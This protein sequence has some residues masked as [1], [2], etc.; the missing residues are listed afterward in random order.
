VD[1]LPGR[2]SLRTDL[3][4][5]PPQFS[6]KIGP[7]EVGGS[8]QL[9]E[10]SPAVLRTISEMHQPDVP[11]SMLGTNLRLAPGAPRETMPPV[12][13]EP[14]M[15]ML[16]HTATASALAAANPRA[17]LSARSE[18]THGHEAAPTLTCRW[19]GC[20]TGFVLR[21]SLRV[22]SDAAHCRVRG[23]QARCFTERPQV[24]KQETEACPTPA[25]TTASRL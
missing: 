22:G 10:V 8:P 14:S 11:P 2:L 21:L 9:K 13:I 6:A 3:L 19:I 17:C 7:V 20:D 24:R 25:Q 16:P 5:L 23:A 15:P 18:S 12:A 1:L 4:A